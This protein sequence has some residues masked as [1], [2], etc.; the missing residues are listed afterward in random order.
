M[1]D[2]LVVYQRQEVVRLSLC[3]AQDKWLYPHGK[4]LLGI[5]CSHCMYKQLHLRQLGLT[6]NS[7]QRQIL[8][9]VFSHDYLSQGVVLYSVPENIWKPKLL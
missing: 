5:N 6:V 9:L 3:N 4:V 1:Q 7:R 8:L 2:R